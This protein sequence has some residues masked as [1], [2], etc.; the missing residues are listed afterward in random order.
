M[1]KKI[2][3]KDSVGEYGR[4]DLTDY[5]T[6]TFRQYLEVADRMDLESETLSPLFFH[7][8]PDGLPTVKQLG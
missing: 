7:V 5:V 1:V 2:L 4:E 6:F 3:L 8:Q